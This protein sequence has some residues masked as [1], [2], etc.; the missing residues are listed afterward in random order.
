[1]GNWKSNDRN[2]RINR[3]MERENAFAAVEEYRM[4]GRTT[5]K[6]PRCD[7]KLLINDAGN[8]FDIRCER[9]GCY[10]MRFRGL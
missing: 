8:A 1:M 2:D 6:C 5:R 3:D 9:E 7:G 4:T 10:R